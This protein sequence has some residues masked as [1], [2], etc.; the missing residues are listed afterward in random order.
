MTENVQLWFNQESIVAPP[1]ACA[2]HKTRTESGP[3]RP[4]SWNTTFTVNTLMEKI[5]HRICS[6]LQLEKLQNIT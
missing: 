6:S 2:G 4:F 1:V 5:Y 3:G